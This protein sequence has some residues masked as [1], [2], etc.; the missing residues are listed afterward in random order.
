[1]EF[2]EL[3]AIMDAKNTMPNEINK[4]LLG[5]TMPINYTP[6]SRKSQAKK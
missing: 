5:L 3:A 4:N 1:M 6:K 2:L